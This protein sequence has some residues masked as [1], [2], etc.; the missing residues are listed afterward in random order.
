MLMTICIGTVCKVKLTKEYSH[1]VWKVWQSELFACNK[2]IYHSAFTLWKLKPTTGLLY[3][4]HE[5]IF[6]LNIETRKKLTTTGN[7]HINNDTNRIYPNQRAE[8]SGMMSVQMAFERCTVSPRHH[9]LNSKERNKYIL[10]VMHI[11][12]DSCVKEVLISNQQQQL[13][14]QL[15]ILSHTQKTFGYNDGPETKIC[16]SVLF[17]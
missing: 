7:F 6:N 11:D 14:V 15:L 12:E 2:T 3:K 16:N 4:R 5:D 9:L 17:T 13:I 10:H 1:R 8:G